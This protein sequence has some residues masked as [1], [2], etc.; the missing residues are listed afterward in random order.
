MRKTEKTYTKTEEKKRDTLTDV[1][2]ARNIV[3][4]LSDD[5][6]IGKASQNGIE[7][8]S[9]ALNGDLNEKYLRNRIETA[10]ED[11]KQQYEIDIYNMSQRQF[12]HVLRY[13]SN[14]V[15]KTLNIDYRQVNILF[16][17][18]DIY[19]DICGLY[20]KTTSVYGYSMFINMPYSTLIN[21][22]YNDNTIRDIYY[23]ITNNIII[24][25]GL[26]DI[27]KSMHKESV[28]IK[29][30]KD[31]YRELLKKI[32][33]DREHALT[34]KAENGSVMSLAL[35]KIEYSWIESAKEKLQV[36]IM[37]NYRL[38]SDLLNKY[39]DN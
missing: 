22:R 7:T 29:V 12:N 9:E 19:I 20:N 10:I 28:I 25:C 36:E 6:N 23:D 21:N 18:A 38:P 11:Y 8:I 26:L 30:S 17:L 34:D 4:G 5:K 35:G 15:I 39:S 37:E 32:S 31:I 1:R 24:E 33:N 3:P 27:Y 14:T 16:I 2:A 13:L